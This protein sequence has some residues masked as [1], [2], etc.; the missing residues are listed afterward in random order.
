M[1]RQSELAELSRVYDNGTLSNRN[2]IV[3]GGMTI[4]QRGTSLATAATDSYLLDRIRYEK[5]G[6]STVVTMSQ[7]TD[8]PAGVSDK[9]LKFQITT[10]GASTPSSGHYHQFIYKGEGNTVDHIG[11]GTSD[12]KPMVLSFYA[13]A[14]TTGTLPFSIHNDTGIVVYSS[15]YNI[16]TA[17]TWQRYTYKLPAVTTGTW[18][19]GTNQGFAIRFGLEYGSDFTGGTPNQ[20]R[21]LASGFTGSGGFQSA[22][23]NALGSTLNATLNITGIQLEMGTE[24]TPFE[25]RSFGDELARCQRYYSVLDSQFSNGAYYRYCN[26]FMNAAA[27]AQGTYHFPVEMRATPTLTASGTIA[28]YDGTN[29]LNAGSVA[30]GS[31]GSGKQFVSIGLG[32]IAS[33]GVQYR[34]CVILSGGNTTSKIEFSA[35]L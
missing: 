23:T 30:I 35:E 10:A 18:L 17:D 2:I 29:V 28:V 13:K 9:S 12:C 22:Y 6:V 25:V 27:A 34:P 19:T 5:S 7:A 3:N 32:S 1:S 4:S 31:D 26:A 20:W 24:A 15:T 14:S 21:T 33:G 16:A 8:G 11:L